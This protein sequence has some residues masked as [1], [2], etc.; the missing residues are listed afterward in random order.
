MS[1][2]WSCRGRPGSSI[3]QVTRAAPSSA[4]YARIPTVAD[5]CLP[6]SQQTSLDERELAVAVGRLVEIHEVH[7]DLRPGQ[8]AVVLRVE[9]DERL[10]ER[11]QA[12][13]P[14][15]GRA[16]RMHPGDYADA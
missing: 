15:L 10:A 6:R 2:T 3:I 12:G 5:D 9:M 16:E 13:D 1:I 8:V 11:R 14:H 4:R 7:V